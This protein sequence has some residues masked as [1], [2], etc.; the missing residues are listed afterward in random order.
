M[1][2]LERSDK[3]V[4]EN[5]KKSGLLKIGSM[6]NLHQPTNRPIIYDLLNFFAFCLSIAYKYTPSDN[7]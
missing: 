2:C 4:S 3:A 1:Q 6:C 5:L 7:V